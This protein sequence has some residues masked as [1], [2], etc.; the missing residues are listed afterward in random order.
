M[1]ETDQT[2]TERV[3]A[4]RVRSE[5]FAATASSRAREFVHEHPVASIAGGIVVGALV[6]GVLSR[7]S[8]HKVT[9]N[10]PLTDAAAARL[11]RM[12]ALGAEMVLAYA[13]RAATAGKD[14]A[15]QISEKSTEAGHK[16]ADFAELALTALREA[17]T[18]ALHR[19]NKRD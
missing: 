10:T 3:E 6:A 11:N 13:A 9:I 17:G 16:V 12:A 7:R 8:G 14:G 5:E 1:T 15:E 2:L 19:L 18:N 4:A